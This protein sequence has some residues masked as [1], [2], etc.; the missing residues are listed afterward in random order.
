[1]FKFE[2]SEQLTTVILTA[3]A[4]QP[5]EVSFDAFVALRSQMAQ[6]RVPLQTAATAPPEAKPVTNG[7]AP[8]E[9]NLGS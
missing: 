4:K 8:P 5:L 6:Q 7:S 2:L 3:L 9:P 1:M